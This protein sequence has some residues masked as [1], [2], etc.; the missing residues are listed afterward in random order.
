[1]RFPFPVICLLILLFATIT[2]PA[3]ADQFKDVP[4]DHWAA[5][6][7]SAVKASGVMKGYPDGTF[8]GEQPIT[9]YELAAALVNMIDHIE[10]SLR[11]EIK[12]DAKPAQTSLPPPVVDKSK[13]VPKG[14]SAQIL[15]NGGFIGIDS[16]LLKDFDKSINSSEL[17]AA[18][19]SVTKRLIEINIP[20][21][22]EHQP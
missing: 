10:N 18:L 21:P 8:K 6:Y 20:A 2:S 14:Y 4:D 3:S 11:P 15:K 1:M 7:V 13:P 17:V 22:T 12:T 5:E 16:P 19:S 9:R